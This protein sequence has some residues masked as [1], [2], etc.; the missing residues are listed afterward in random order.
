MHLDLRLIAILKLLGLKQIKIQHINKNVSS[1]SLNII[2]KLL[3]DKKMKNRA[4][5]I[6]TQYSPVV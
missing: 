1:K 6:R 5:W 3:I 4:L 2:I